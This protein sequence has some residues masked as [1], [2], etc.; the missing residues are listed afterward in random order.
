MAPAPEDGLAALTD[1]LFPP[2]DSTA[3]DTLRRSFGDGFRLLAMRVQSQG[4]SPKLRRRSR[5]GQLTESPFYRI[6]GA[7][8]VIVERWFAGVLS[9]SDADVWRGEYGRCREQLT[10]IHWRV[11]RE[12][13]STD[14]VYWSW[15]SAVSREWRRWWRS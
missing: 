10:E 1:V 8:E 3:T 5:P 13:V 15:S 14:V 6:G 11:E 7:S 9:A 12:G 2:D 4:L